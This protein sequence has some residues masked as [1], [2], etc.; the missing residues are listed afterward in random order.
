MRILGAGEPTIGL[1]SA[2][3][4]HWGHDKFYSN[5]HWRRQPRLIRFE[6]GQIQQAISLQLGAVRLT[7]RFPEDADAPLTLKIEASMRRHVTEQL[8]SSDF[9]FSPLNSRS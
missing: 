6:A 1:G 4:R 2:G 8:M 9:D 5:R 3:D 7:E